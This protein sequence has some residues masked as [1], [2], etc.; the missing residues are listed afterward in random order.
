MR[1]VTSLL[2][3]RAGRI[4]YEEYFH[5]GSRGRSASVA[6][7]TKS[8]TSYLIG[9]A[10]AQGLIDSVGVPVVQLLPKFQPPA[11]SS[12]NR[13]TI[14]QLLTMTSGINDDWYQLQ[15]PMLRVLQPPGSVFHYSNEGVGFLV[16]I[17]IAT[18]QMKLQQFANRYLMN[19][20]GIGDVDLPERWP[21]LLP[22]GSGDGAGGLHLTSR[23]L[24]K[25]GL[26]GLRQGCWEGR[27]VVPAAYVRAAMQKQVKAAASG[28]TGD[29]YGY[30]W[31]I[32]EI[33]GHEAP[34][35]AGYGGQYV[36]VIPDLDLVAIVT[37]D[38]AIQGDYRAQFR[39][40]S[41]GV[42]G[43]IRD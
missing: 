21:P 33:N 22:D 43:A 18:S 1:A 25:L 11:Q 20:L 39:L 29:D 26:L 8:I 41:H 6:S 34:Y 10:L 37:A 3:I 7:I 24:G 4:V 19:P 12:A 35:M 13:M 31:W 42:V 2:V 30:L 40:L 28:P 5:G 27:Q 23:E 9:I 32:A 36:M 15:P 17:L 14:R 16:R 38:Q